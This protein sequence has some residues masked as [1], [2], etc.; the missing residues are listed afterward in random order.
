MSTHQFDIPTRFIYHV[1]FI[2]HRSAVFIQDMNT[3]IVIVDYGAGNLRSVVNAVRSLGHEPHLTA[4]PAEIT[5]AA[6]VILPGVGEGSAAMTELT[7][8]GLAEALQER[9]KRNL[10]LLGVCLGLQVLMG[11]TEEGGDVPCLNIVPGLVRKLPENHKIPHMGWNQVK[12][13]RSHTIFEGIPDNAYFYFV[14]SYY[15]DPQ[16]KTAVIGATDY[17]EQF[18]SV[19]A[20]GS[21]IATQFHPEKSGETGL[22]LYGNFLRLALGGRTC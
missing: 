13:L 5:S 10:P 19:L 1:C 8:L 17:G 2:R 15:A 21:V 16:D 6:A 11:T 14:H 4:D 3:K 20:Q 9:G 12:Q 7:R 18:C 22:R